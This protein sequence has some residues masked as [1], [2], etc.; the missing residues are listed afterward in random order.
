MK[1][2]FV[3][4]KRASFPFSSLNMHGLLAKNQRTET[5]TIL[6]TTK[7]AGNRTYLHNYGST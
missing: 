5:G 1:K 3:V 2:L 4:V 6:Y 7:A